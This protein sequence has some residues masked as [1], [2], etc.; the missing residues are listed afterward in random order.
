MDDIS[1]WAHMCSLMCLCVC[2]RTCTCLYKCV[3]EYVHANRTTTEIYTCGKSPTKE[4]YNVFDPQSGQSIRR[5]KNVKRD[6]LAVPS[7]RTTSLPT[8]NPFSVVI[9]LACAPITV[10]YLSSFSFLFFFSLATDQSM[11]IEYMHPQIHNTCV[12]HCW[13]YFRSHRT[14]ST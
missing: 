10:S 4:T 7:S 8:A 2:F 5:K 9:S 13:K 11:S 1:M 3:Y 6:T 14:L 12:C